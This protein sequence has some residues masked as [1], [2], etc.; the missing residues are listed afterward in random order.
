MYDK[1]V[2]KQLTEEAWKHAQ[3]LSLDARNYLAG[4]GIDAATAE[5]YLLGQPDYGEFDGWLSIPYIRRG[6]VLWTNYRN[7]IP[8]HKPKYK[9]YGGKHL[10]NTDVLDQAD[11]SGTIYVCEGELDAIMATESGYPS[12][13]IPGATQFQGQPV[14]HELLRH[15]PRI[16]ILGDPDDAGRGLAREICDRLPQ[17]RLVSLPADVTDTVMNYGGLEQYL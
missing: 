10:Y 1:Q 2:V 7:L 4:R 14:W 9:S 6:K 5:R 15:Y 11:L 16:L 12:V 8:E 17:A 13:G 3:T